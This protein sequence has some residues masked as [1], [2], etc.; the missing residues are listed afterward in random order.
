MQNRQLD[1]AEMWTGWLTNFN[2]DNELGKHWDHVLRAMS[3][4]LLYTTDCHHT[5]Y[6]TFDNQAT[7]YIN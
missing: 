3:V 5:A 2:S 4:T 6:V 1:F 7:S